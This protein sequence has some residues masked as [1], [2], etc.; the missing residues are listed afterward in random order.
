MGSTG[1][2]LVEYFRAGGPVMWLLLACS[3]AGL[4]IIFYKAWQF[5]MCSGSVDPLL[6]RVEQC[7]KGGDNE[8]A[9]EACGAFRGPVGTVVRAAVVR[10]GQRKEVIR[11]AVQDVGTHEIASLESFLPA[12]QTVGNIAPLLGFLG[13]VLGMIQA[14][15]AISQAGLGDPGVVANGIAQALITTATGLIVAVPAFVF[16]NYFV[17]R[18]NGYA[19]QIERAASHVVNLVAA[20]GGEAA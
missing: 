8:G 1:Y 5:L 18:V 11:E 15:F 13:T 10:A 3:V 6:H 14:F 9:S 17:A 12:L 4:G 16:Y 20:D 7:V 2:P 19:L